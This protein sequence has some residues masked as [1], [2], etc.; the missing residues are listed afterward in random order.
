MG[1]SSTRG[2]RN[3]LTGRLR[4]LADELEPVKPPWFVN[5]PEHRSRTPSMGWW[6][7]PAGQQYPVYLG[8][9]HIVAEMQL[10]DVLAGQELPRD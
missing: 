9:N 4:E 6:W 5:H 8:H 3:N 7:V 1:L 10:R 2:R